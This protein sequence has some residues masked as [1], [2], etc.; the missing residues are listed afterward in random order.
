MS[1]REI[2]SKG[3]GNWG[4]LGGEKMITFGLRNLAAEME[5]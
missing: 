1:Q 3:N 4:C 2:K 5:R